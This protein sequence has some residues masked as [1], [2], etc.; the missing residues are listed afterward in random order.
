MRAHWISSLEIADQYILKGDELHHLVNVVRI[1]KE[2]PLLLLN[3]Q[4]LM[5]ETQVELI[6]KKEL[7]LKKNKH[8]LGVRHFEFDLALG[9]PKR[10]AL[11]LCLK[12]ATE[13]G[14]KRIYLVKSDFSQMRFPEKDRT[15]KILISALEQSNAPFLP[16]VILSE[17]GEIPINRY[18]KVLL[19]DSQTTNVQPKVEIQGGSEELLIVGP[20][21]GFSNPEIQ[22]LHS[23]SNI[24]IV[25]LPTPILR[26]PTAVATGAGIMIESLLK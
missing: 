18:K 2:E 4:G 12:E 16:E 19:L 13:L 8:S 3:G 14:F 9:M 26:S 5:I 7:F 10:E 1:E 20:E 11:E 17:W 25:N 21:G 24:K 22:F 23:Q 6:S 15:E